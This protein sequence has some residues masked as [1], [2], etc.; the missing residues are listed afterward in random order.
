MST[1][2]YLSSEQ[3][4]AILATSTE[5]V[6]RELRRKKMRGAK[7]GRSWRIT[8]E[9]VE[10]YVESHMNVSKVRGRSA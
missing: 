5:Y 7:V 9:D 3:V 6:E 8:A 1:P 4:A 2:A 10:R